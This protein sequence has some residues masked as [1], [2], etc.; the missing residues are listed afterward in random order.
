[1]GR[2]TTPAIRS[3]DVADIV[4]ELETAP[5]RG[6]G[7]KSRLYL[8]LQENHDQLVREFAR[9]PPSW[10]RLAA[11]LG[12]RG[13]LDGDGKPPTARGA[14]GAWYRVR[15]DVAAALT[16]KASRAEAAAFGIHPI[17]ETAP[18]APASLALP[19]S[20]QLDEDEPDR[21][22]FRLASLRGATA[23]DGPTSPDQPPT[24]PAKTPALVPQRFAD[25]MAE[26]LGQ[27][28]TPPKG[29]E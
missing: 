22:V 18:V 13:V 19:V 8:W 24:S 14:R 28:P 9:N 15:R 23:A 21:P 10:T 17:A 16:K 2:N 26:F 27:S 11:I 4:A 5:A 20:I 25:V 1:M 7:R 3:F 6:H 29:D 12:A